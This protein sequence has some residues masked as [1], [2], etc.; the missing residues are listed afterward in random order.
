MSAEAETQQLNSSRI[1]AWL[2]SGVRIL[3]RQIFPFLTVIWIN[4]VILRMSVRDSVEILAPLYY[5]TPWPVLAVLTLVLL[6]YFW[7]QPLA[8]FAILFLAHMLGAAWIMESWRS[9]PLSKAPADLRVIQW[10]VAHP[11]NSRTEIMARIQGFDADI[12]ALSEPVPDSGKGKAMARASSA[13]EEWR[14]AFREYAYE[15]RGS[16]LLCLIR[17]EVLGRRQGVLHPGSPYAL[18]EARVKGHALRILQVD[19]DARPVHPRRA[20]LAALVELVGTL[21]DEPLILIGDFNTPRE[22]VY[23]DPLQKYLQHAWLTAGSGCAET[24]PAF[25][26]VLS[27]DQIWCGY[28]LHAIRCQHGVTFRS[29]HRPVVAELKFEQT[30]N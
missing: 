1:P 30:T 6:R 28:G 20:P 27:L 3:G 21:G 24:W 8:V 19:V 18:Y 4:G 13:A 10:N 29:D 25:L 7:R 12:I 2:F 11:W 5:A 14:V 22:S 23:L 15:R 26:P 16:E 9:A 17:G